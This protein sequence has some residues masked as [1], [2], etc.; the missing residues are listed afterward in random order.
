MR[1]VRTTG[2]AL[3]LVTLALLSASTGP[4]QERVTG[5]EKLGRVHFAVSCAAPA[6]TE[7]DR[8]VALLHSFWWGPATDTFERVLGHDP[9][10]GM[11]HWGIAMAALGNPFGGPPPA[12]ALAD[13]AAAL[14]QAKTVG[15]RSQ[16]ERDYIA[17]LEAFYRDHATVDHRTRAVAYERAMGELAGRYPDD[18]EATVFYALALNATVLPTDKTFANQLK[19]ADLL[20]KVFAEQPDHPGV[21]HYLI[22][23]YDYAP[24]AGRGLSAAR[25]YL[26]IAPSVPH[27]LHMPSHIFTRLA[28]WSEAIESNRASAAAAT[29]DFDRMHAMDYLVYAYLQTGQDAA[30]RR[31]AGELAA[32]GKPNVVHLATAYAM[33]AGPARLALERQRWTEAAGLTVQPPDFV[34]NRFPQGEAITQFARA[35]GAARSGDPAAARRSVE[36]LQALHATLVE[37]KSAYWAG[38]VEIQRLAAS[39]WLAFKEGRAAEAVTLLRSAADREDASEKHPATPA[40][41]LPAREQL[42]DL[43]LEQGQ[44]ADA[45]REYQAA[46]T[47]EPGRLRGLVGAARAAVRAGQRDIARKHYTDLLALAAPADTALAELAEA[48]NF[49]AQR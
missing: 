14:G 5:A 15:A 42:A 19:A 40:P 4:A 2:I 43:L 20:E 26:K 10:C 31:V 32:I 28:L 29:N 17:A 13:G 21:A 33:A 36:R 16:R 6:Q 34:W 47:K 25:R 49:L 22:H 3:G 37:A 8:A 35:V 41:V 46:A 44:P 39:G 24:I 1:H 48:R 12:K 9:A 45:L 7:F 23:S 11:A 18:R 38:Q 30:A 27:A